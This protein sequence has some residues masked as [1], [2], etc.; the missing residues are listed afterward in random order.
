LT[1]RG[2]PGKGVSLS[3]PVGDGAPPPR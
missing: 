2:L 3:S 1:I